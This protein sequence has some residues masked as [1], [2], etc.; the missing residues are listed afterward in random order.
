MIEHLKELYRRI[1]YP[2]SY[3]S[4]ALVSYLN[5][6]GAKV[7]SHTQI[8][9]PHK[10]HIDLLNA[11][12]IE[13]GDYCM[14]TEGVVILAH[15][16]S[17]AVLAN[18][19]HDL[20]RKQRVTKIGNNVFIG[21]NSIILMGAEVGDDVVI[22]AGSV[23]VGRLEG[24]AVYSGNPARRICSLEEYHAKREQDYVHSATIYATKADSVEEMG[25]YRCMFEDEE[26][27]K[28]YLKGIHLNGVKPEAI[29]GFHY[30][31][32]R[33]KWESMPHK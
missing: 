1:A 17:Y 11:R 29:S 31:G 2:H 6:R 15:D 32:E 21:M 12:F 25:V 13:I 5:S 27:F 33:L 22:G 7:G 9:A 20:Y 16:Y 19:Y 18:V 23:V 30:S 3:N 26:S 8:Y 4:T 14:I 28:Q 10:H 24:N